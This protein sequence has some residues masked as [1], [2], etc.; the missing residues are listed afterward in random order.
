MGKQLP[1]K[2]QQIIQSHA[3]MIVM[4]VQATQ[5]ASVR[6]QLKTVLEATE[7]N[8]WVALAKAIRAIVAGE[9][10]PR[11][12]LAPLDEEDSTIIAAVLKGIQNPTSLPDPNQKADASAAAPAIAQMIYMTAQGDAQSKI[13]L[14][15]MADQM[16]LAGG[17][18]AHLSGMMRRLV[19]GERDANILC[20]GMDDKGEKLILSIV[21]ELEKLD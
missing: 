19:E 10:S 16:R 3:A 15:G 2:Q 6:P 21:E 12:L 7:K 17:D 13:M 1:A 18:M 11:R 9:R 20:H 5:N 4:I 14:A 8:G